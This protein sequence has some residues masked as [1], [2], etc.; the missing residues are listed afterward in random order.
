MSD[1]GIKAQISEKIIKKVLAKEVCVVYNYHC[2]DVDSV[3]A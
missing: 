2:C 3:E 1:K